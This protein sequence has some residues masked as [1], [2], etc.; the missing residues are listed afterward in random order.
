M[1]IDLSSYLSATTLGNRSPAQERRSDRSFGDHSPL[2][3]AEGIIVGASAI[4]RDITERKR[5]EAQIS[6]LAREAEHRAKNLLSHQ[7]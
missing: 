4:A 6:I 2:R 1:E 7:T 5:S 3:D